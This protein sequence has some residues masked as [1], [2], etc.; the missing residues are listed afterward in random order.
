MATA[1][2]EVQANHAMWH[3]N[4]HEYTFDVKINMQ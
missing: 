3:K 4:I 1:K 2:L